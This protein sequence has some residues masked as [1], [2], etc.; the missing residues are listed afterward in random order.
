MLILSL[1]LERKQILKNI[2]CMFPELPLLMVRIF[3]FLIRHVTK[4]FNDACKFLSLL[5][6]LRNLDFSP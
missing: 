2:F 4:T 1:G 5:E 3:R 6:V